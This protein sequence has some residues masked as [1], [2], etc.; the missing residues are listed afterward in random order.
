MNGTPGDSSFLQNVYRMY[1][2]AATALR[3][4]PGL[5]ENIKHCRQVYQVRFPL[6]IRGEIRNF[7]GWRASHSEHRLP[8]KGGIRFSPVVDQ[9][10]VEA[11]A[12][13][14][15]F[16]CALVNVPFGGSKGGLAI[17]PAD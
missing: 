3:L 6:R 16:K 15:S 9:Q 7:T 14:M 1:D 11:L 17:D 13:L 4:P 2:R 12:A 8:A 10:E 5:I